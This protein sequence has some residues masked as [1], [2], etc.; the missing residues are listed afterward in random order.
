MTLEEKFRE[1]MLELKLNAR[2]IQNKLLKGPRAKS[3]LLELIVSYRLN[4]IMY[5]R[6]LGVDPYEAADADV[7]IFKES[8]GD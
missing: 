6:E 7:R 5:Y 1:R 2:N 4:A 8:L 3:R